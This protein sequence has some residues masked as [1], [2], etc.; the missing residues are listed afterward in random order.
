MELVVWRVLDL[1]ITQDLPNMQLGI[2]KELSVFHMCT[3]HYFIYISEDELVF[4]DL[5][6]ESQKELIRCKLTPDQQIELNDINA[7]KQGLIFYQK[8]MLFKDNSFNFQKEEFLISMEKLNKCD[9]LKTEGE[10]LKNHQFCQLEDGTVFVY[11]CTNDQF[12]F[13]RSFVWVANYQLIP[14]QN[15]FFYQPGCSIVSDSQYVC[16]VG[17]SDGSKDIQIFEILGGFWTR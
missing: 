4:L 9:L 1:E 13:P 5:H 7:N 6:D 10:Q 17:S 15:S 2:K 8:H 12:Q 16:L 11:C 3:K 14:C